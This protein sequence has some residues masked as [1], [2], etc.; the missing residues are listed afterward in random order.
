MR[1]TDNQSEKQ[2]HEVGGEKARRAA[3]RHLGVGFLALLF[4]LFLISWCSLPGR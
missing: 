4:L 1:Q 3:I 2:E